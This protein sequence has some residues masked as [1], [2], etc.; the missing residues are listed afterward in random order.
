MAQACGSIQAKFTG[1]MSTS[2]DPSQ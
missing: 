1:Q 2:S